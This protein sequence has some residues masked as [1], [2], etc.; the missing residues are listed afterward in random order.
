ML[1]A[2]NINDKILNSSKCVISFFFNFIQNEC[3][4]RAVTAE[5]KN[6]EIV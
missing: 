3:N 6:N 5:R 1:R 2:I 4:I